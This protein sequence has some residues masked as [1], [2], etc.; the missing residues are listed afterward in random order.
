VE[1][2][3]KS[4]SAKRFFG[5]RLTLEELDQL[6]RFQET[7]ELATRSEA[8]RALLR[9]ASGEIASSSGIPVALRAQMESIVHDGWARDADEAL[10]LVLSFGLG[11]LSRLHAER[12]PA[13]R[14]AARETT[15]RSQ[16]RRRAGHTGRELLKR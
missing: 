9:A 13:L 1:T 12:L 4:G 16:G 11:E 14:R 6:D 3:R 15:E 10:T 7:N 8:V 5:V 2:A